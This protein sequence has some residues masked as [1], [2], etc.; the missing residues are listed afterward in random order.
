MVE[1]TAG[2][3]CFVRY[4]EASR[5]ACPSDADRDEQVF[6]ESPSAGAV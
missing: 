2:L 4:G 6:N 5:R 1:S 3:I